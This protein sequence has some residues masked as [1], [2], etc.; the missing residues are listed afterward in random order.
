MYISLGDRANSWTYVWTGTSE[1][2]WPKRDRSNR[3]PDVS[4][5]NILSRGGNASR[6]RLSYYD[7]ARAGTQNPAPRTGGRTVPVSA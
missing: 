2:P 1:N 7:T 5:G 3:L 6:Q 4:N